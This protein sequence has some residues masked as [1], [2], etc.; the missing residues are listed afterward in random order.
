MA[1]SLITIAKTSSPHIHKGR[2]AGIVGILTLIVA[3]FGYL[4]E[5]SLAARF[6]VSTTMD[7]YFGAIF[8]PNI[9]YLILISGTLSPIF[10]PILLQENG[11]HDLSRA[12]E[13]FSVITSFIL[14]LFLG[15]V[16]CGMLAAPLWLPLL[17]RGFSPSTAEMT[18]QLVRLLFPAVLFL[19]LAGILTALLNGFHKFALA[20]T[21][22]A[23]SSIAVIIATFVAKGNR[24]VYV[25]TLATAIGFVLQA[26][27]LIPA[28]FSLGIRYR[29]NFNFS[30]S[31]I[32]KLIRLGVPLFLYLLAANATVVVE[33]NLASRISAG[34][35]S[36][37][38]YA[39]RLF[40]VPSNLLAAPLAIV[41]YPGFARE[42]AREQRGDLANQASRLFR[43]V[44]F[45]F[46][47]VTLW[48]ILNALPVTQLLYEHGHF[49]ASDSFS[50]SR[51]LA[52]Y[53]L[54]ILPNAVAIILLRC[55]FAIEDTVT[56]LLTE[57]V[58][59]MCF[60]IAA[61]VLSRRFGLDGLAAARAVTFYLVVGVLM[62]VL[63]RRRLLKLD[64][65]FLGFLVRTVLATA[66]MG[67]VDW[68]LIREL[69]SL[70][71]VSGTM[72]RL[73]GIC[74]LLLA[75]TATFLGCARFLKLSQAN[76]ITSTVLG[77]LP[78]NNNHSR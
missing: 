3:G 57:I 68:V 75:S 1:E 6:G 7:A 62:I 29:P 61:G 72:V 42:A 30:H 48:T 39:L 34:S 40:T 65:D 76:Q 47:P 12:S 31:A 33:R 55:Y 45:L 59:L 20:A 8:V 46:F 69:H 15:I 60:T 63:A 25:V 71:G 13:T 19:A 23:L 21:A 77:L 28:A 27:L 24:A 64:F 11:D 38:S 37:L 14:L 4:R 16:V 56:P 41:A 67:V 74:I 22:P 54:G 2:T 53:S 26:L 9:I 44:V 73:A 43:L 5:A 78:W 32:R 36:I 17:F 58:N 49:L 66:I 51:I 50:T 70:L 10:I 18:I 52:I 35:V